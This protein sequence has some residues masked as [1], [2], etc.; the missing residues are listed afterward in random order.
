MET[1]KHIMI[2]SDT[3]DKFSN[4]FLESSISNPFYD[5]NIFFTQGLRTTKYI[6]FQIIGNLG[7]YAD[8][9]E[10]NAATD[11]YVIADSLLK[12]MLNGQ[13]DSQ[14]QELEKKMN[15]KGKKH[16]KLT[17][18]SEASF[19][20]HVKKRCDEIGDNVTLNLINQV[21]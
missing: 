6:E 21:P 16:E 13:K 12:D 14:L 8:D 11:Y 17:I 20:K 10:F 7:G 1:K 9:I 5:K 19:L 3:I 15:A 2:D 18:I 4:D